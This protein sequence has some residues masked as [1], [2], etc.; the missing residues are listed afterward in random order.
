MGTATRVPQ[1]RLMGGDELAADDAWRALRRYGVRPLVRDAFLRFRYGDGFSHARALGLQICLAALPGLIAVVGLSETLHQAR[2]GRLAI[3]V[4]DRLSPGASHD[5]VQRAL[6]A[7]QR[8]ADQG[9]TV[10]LGFGLAFA[11][12]ALTT[13]MAQVERGANRIYGVERD[14][15]FV[16]KYGM[17]LLMAVTAGLAIGLGLL[18]L[19]AGHAIGVAL[20]DVYGWPAG[21]VRVWNVLRWPAGILLAL[22]SASVLFRWSPRR[23][24]PGYS[25][26]AVGAGLA[27]VLWSVFTGALTL[28]TVHS[29]TFGNTYGP[30]TAVM[31]LLLWAN[32]SGIALLFGLA[33]A[34]QL[35][36]CRAGRP[37]PVTSDPGG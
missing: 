4:L 11:L 32:L 5:V 27:L 2:F 20:H 17:A 37:A 24:Q 13:A 18:L 7:S 29:S 34:A 15:P 36:S 9:G 23:R 30:L 8:H 25:W 12:I 16:R 1:T 3:I 28:Y 35:E 33:F 26:L 31:A 21:R 22:L 19:V 14:R 6:T 10:A